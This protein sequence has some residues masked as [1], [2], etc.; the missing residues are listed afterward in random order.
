[1]FHLCQFFLFYCRNN[2][3]N[4]I[5]AFGKA[6]GRDSIRSK[7]LGGERGGL[8]GEGEPFSRKVPLPPPTSISI[9]HIVHE[10]DDPG[11]GDEGDGE[12]RELHA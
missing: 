7:V 3:I 10:R 2:I 11:D 8:E 6:E 5:Y 1:M 4:A 9:Q 12:A